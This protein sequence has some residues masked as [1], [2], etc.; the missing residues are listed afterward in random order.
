MTI[1]KYNDNSIKVMLLQRA[2]RVTITG[3]FALETARAVTAF[4]TKSKLVADGIVGPKTLAVMFPSGLPEFVQKPELVCGDVNLNLLSLSIPPAILTE[5]V[6]A[7]NK[8]K[9]PIT[10]LNVAHLLGQVQHESAN[11]TRG[12][13]NMN[14]SASRLL[15][16]FP[17]TVTNSTIAKRLANKPEDIANWVYANR[18]GNGDVA[19]GDGWRFRG[20]GAIQ[21]TGRDNFKEMAKDINDQFI[22]V[23]TDLLTKQ[24]RML[25]AVWFFTQNKIWNKCKGI[26]SADT[27]AVTKII[28]PS[29]QKLTERAMNTN[30]LFTL[31]N[32]P[33]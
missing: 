20:A 12:R 3:V 17:S 6:A 8:L 5:T 26:T 21:L 10:K 19:S 13:E 2:L 25:A 24:Y 29:M 4:Q 28:N 11:F 14:Y 31:L 16:I 27:E 22:L 15:Q 7:F 30:I 18:L 9:V 23:D 33:S 1:I 32:V